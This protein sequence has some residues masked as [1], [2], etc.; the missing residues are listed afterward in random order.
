MPTS[1]QIVR[2]VIPQML[3]A[4]LFLGGWGLQQ[5]QLLTSTYVGSMGVYT[6][7]ALLFNAVMVSDQGLNP[8]AAHTSSSHLCPHLCSHLH[9][10]F[11]AIAGAVPPVLH[12]LD[13]RVPRRPVDLRGANRR[14]WTEV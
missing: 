2:L 6:G 11:P 7:F 1:L 4:A 8:R 5:A 13:A 12:R 9:S 3:V 14:V 10:H